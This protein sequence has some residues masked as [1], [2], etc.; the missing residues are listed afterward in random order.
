MLF[1]EYDS[2][3]S[4]TYESLDLGETIVSEEKAGKEFVGKSPK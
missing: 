1:T 2:M 3:Q 4:H